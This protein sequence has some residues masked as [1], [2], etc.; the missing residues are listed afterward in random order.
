[1]HFNK[2]QNVGS[3]KDRIANNVNAFTFIRS[4]EWAKFQSKPFMISFIAFNFQN[5]PN[6][7]ISFYNSFWYLKLIP[8]IHP[9]GFDTVH[10]VE[11]QVSQNLYQN[12]MF[13][14]LFLLC[15]D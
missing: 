13:H 5:R 15:S 14:H 3:S 8:N 7:V 4:T 11:N 6:F 12:K 10:P 1:M 2:I 9:C